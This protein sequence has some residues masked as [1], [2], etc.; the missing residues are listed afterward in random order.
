MNR[1]FLYS[2]LLLSL[3]SCSSMYKI[4]GVSSV[5]S[6]DGK[7]LYIKS[8]QGEEWQTLDSAEVIHGA[9]SMKGDVD[10]VMMVTLYIGEESVMPMI[11]EKGNIEVSIT[12]MQLSARGT[13][14]NNA[15]YDFI[16]RKNAMDLK[17]EELERKEARMVM[18]GND[19]SIIHEQLNKEGEELANEMNKSV[20]AFIAD[21]YENVL[22]PSVFMMLCSSLP[23]PILTPQ[24]NDILKDA[25]ASFKDNN[26]V[27]E[28]ISK[29]K[30]NEELIEE[31]K[32]LQQNL[33]LRN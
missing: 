18:D 10:S 22:G 8:L 13:S 4:A 16:D 14:L 1:F 12:N 23:Y 6:L 21:N 2:L 28:F 19:L 3:T 24:I 26:M 7:M 31:Q 5:R 20:K 29:A 32:R 30:E 11:L 17:I 15:L 9:F 25:P 33:Q 27:K